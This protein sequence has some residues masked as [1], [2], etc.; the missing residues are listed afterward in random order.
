MYEELGMHDSSF[1]AVF[2]GQ[3]LELPSAAALSAAPAKKSG[4]LEL[5]DKVG[6]RSRVGSGSSSE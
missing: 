6:F 2:P 5:V 3:S 1:S 4:D